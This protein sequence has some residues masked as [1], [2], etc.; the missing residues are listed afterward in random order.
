MIL[1][2]CLDNTEIISM[3]NKN[4]DRKGPKVIGRNTFKYDEEDY[5]HFY[6]FADHANFFKKEHDYLLIGQYVIPDYLIEQYGFGY[7]CGIKTKRNSNLINEEIPIPEV[8]IK[9]DNFKNIFL[10]HVNDRLTPIYQRNMLYQRD[11][12]NRY[13]LDEFFSVD[14]KD[15]HGPPISINYSY[16]DVYYEYID[17]LIRNHPY[18]SIKEI[19]KYYLDCE[20]IKVKL[21][22]FFNDNKD[23][24]IEQNKEYIKRRNNRKQN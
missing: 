6:V 10:N 16:A 9:K 24:F 4:I 20:S 11:E 13:E 7:Y 18:D 12:Y 21:E 22:E 23:Y 15:N 1:Y 3:F 14:S 17:Y 5:K 8:I 2:R 19:V